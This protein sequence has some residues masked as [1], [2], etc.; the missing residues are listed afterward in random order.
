M[1]QQ[2]LLAQ[3]GLFQN[4][5]LEE[6]YTKMKEAFGLLLNRTVERC[7]KHCQHRKDQERYANVCDDAVPGLIERRSMINSST[8]RV[9]LELEKIDALNSTDQKIGALK[10]YAQGLASTQFNALFMIILSGE[11]NKRWLPLAEEQI[12]ASELRIK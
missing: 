9:L 8:N 3:Y 1:K 2:R 10:A 11:L 5:T 7:S 6:K 12:S 4:D